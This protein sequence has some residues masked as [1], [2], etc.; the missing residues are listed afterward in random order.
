MKNLLIFLLVI[1]FSGAAW[2][3]TISGKV[4][5]QGDSTRP[6]TNVIVLL[7]DVQNNSLA[8]YTTGPTGYYQF[9]NVPAGTYS[10][11]GT[12]QQPGGGVSIL[13]AT[14]VL[15][16]VMGIYPFNDIQELAADVNGSGSVTLTDYMLIMN[17]ILHNTPFPVGEW[18][19]LSESIT[20]NNLKDSNPGGLVGSSSGDVGGVFVPGTRNLQ[21][22]PVALNGSMQVSRGQQFDVPLQT[23]AALSITGA[24]L[25]I[26]VPSNLISVQSVDSPLSGFEYSIEG[27]QV[28]LV[29]NNATGTA[30]EIQGETALVTLHCIANTAF[31]EG[32]KTSFSLDGSTSL[33]DKN[34]T[35]IANAGLKIPLVECAKPSLTLS[36]YPNPFTSSTSLS[37]FLPE[38]GPVSVA[39]FN[40]TGQKVSEYT[41]GNQ[42][43]G[44]HSLTIEG[45]GLNSG[46]Y[47]CRVTVTG[48]SESIRILK[49][50]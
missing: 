26:N 22:Y 48:K 7:K 15:L 11:K 10:L 29:W 12:K 14:L 16:H 8:T 45:Q 3:A 5:Y 37:Y 23:S 1:A 47:F 46:Y 19:F 28:R 24:G 20:I 18:V 32:M 40:Q 35:E 6:V 21:A 39:L 50:Q 13:D 38:D 31:E 2:S 25:I 34:Y 4:F 41:P 9:L 44:I 17:H 36:N 43:K 33:V 30:E 49:V 27:N 42:V